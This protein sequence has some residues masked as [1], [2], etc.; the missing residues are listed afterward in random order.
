MYYLGKTFS[1]IPFLATYTRPVR[2]RIGFPI[3]S[4]E[5][6]NADRGNRR[7]P[8]AQGTSL[9]LPFLSSAEIPLPFVARRDRDAPLS[10]CTHRISGPPVPRRVEIV[11]PGASG[12]NTNLLRA[13]T[14]RAPRSSASKRRRRR[15]YLRSLRIERGHCFPLRTPRPPETVHGSTETGKY[16]IGNRS[17]NLRRSKAAF[18]RS[19]GVVRLLLGDIVGLVV[20]KKL[21][22]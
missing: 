7:K 19:Y 15:S 6:R 22:Y 12:K 3:W 9:F 21:S 10:A 1:I 18:T 4:P 20:I 11:P 13:A 8:T 16:T 5:F 17:Q 2:R 14:K